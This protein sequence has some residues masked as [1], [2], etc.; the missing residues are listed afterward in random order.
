MPA[1]FEDFRGWDG[2]ED[3]VSSFW[4]TKEVYQACREVRTCPSVICGSIYDLLGSLLSIFFSFM[5]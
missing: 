3:D 2:E 5:V 1:V 4:W